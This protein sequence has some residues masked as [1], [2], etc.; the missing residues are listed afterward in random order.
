MT[1][2]PPKKPRRSRSLAELTRD[3]INPAAAKLGFGEADVLLH[4]NEIAGERLAAVC[5]P[6]RLQWPVR[7]PNRPPDAPPE[8]ATLILQVEGAFALEAQHLAPLLI[9]RVNARLGWKCIGRISLRQGPVRRR[10]RGR[11]RPL[12]PPPEAVDAAKAAAQDI[13]DEG[14]REALVRLGARALAG[15]TTKS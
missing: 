9:E 14:L 11:G 12:P 15:K 13:A 8:P 10:A 1:F 2:T 4:W 5:E 3:A 6:L 7:A